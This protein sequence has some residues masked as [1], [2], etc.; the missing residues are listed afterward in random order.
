M[1]KGE[2]GKTFHY[3][4]QFQLTTDTIQQITSAE[5]VAQADAAYNYKL[6]E[7]K[8]IRL[9]EGKK[10]MHSLIIL[11]LSVGITM[12]TIFLLIIVYYKQKRALLRYKLERYKALVLQE[13]ERKK[14]ENDTG[15]E[16]EDYDIYKNI[17]Y[18]INNPVSNRRLRT[19]DW[20]ELRKAINEVSPDFDQ[21]LSE[22]CKMSEKDYRL[23]LLLKVGIS[24]SDIKEFINLTSSGVC[25]AR[26]K[27]YGRAF[28]EKKHPEEWDKIISSL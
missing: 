10:N 22:L 9:K 6:R 12:T 1:S 25:S 18:L 14:H 5:A 17:V 13:N 23:C 28:G 2:Q 11:I 26:N 19:E 7:K 15:K 16:I 4:K 27:L 24:L 21:K 8:I 3:L 20:E